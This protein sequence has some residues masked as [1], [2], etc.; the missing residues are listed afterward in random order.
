MESEEI[1]WDLCIIC[2]E[3]KSEALRSTPHG[4]ETLTKN[5][6]DFKSINALPQKLA[7]ICRENCEELFKHMKLNIISMH[8]ILVT[9]IECSIVL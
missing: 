1:N 4:I 6:L 9:T 2:Q 7:S 8:V 5:L 3:S